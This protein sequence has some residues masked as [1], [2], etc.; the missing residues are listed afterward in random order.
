MNL[1]TVQLR[2][3]TR[4]SAVLQ[5]PSRRCKTTTPT[6]NTVLLMATDRPN[7]KPKGHQRP[8]TRSH[9]WQ[10]SSA[11]LT[12]TSW[13]PNSSSPRGQPEA[14][15]PTSWRPRRQPAWCRSPTLALRA[16]PCWANTN[17]NG[18]CQHQSSCSNRRTLRLSWDTSF[19]S[20]SN[21][22]AVG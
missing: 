20:S 22:L 5:G 18:I 1:K 8:R 14:A 21:W 19:T 17:I 15:W 2:K 4:A 16:R 7:P 6:T 11:S 13:R 9:R 12:T 10:I 3:M